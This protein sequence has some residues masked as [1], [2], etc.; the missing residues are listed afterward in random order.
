MLENK[1]LLDGLNIAFLLALGYYLAT[2]LQWYNYSIF[3]V[4][5]KHHKWR[6]HLLYFILPITLFISLSSFNLV[7]IFY[8]YFLFAYLPMLFFWVKKLDKPLKWTGRVYRFFGIYLLFILSDM[9]LQLAYGEN[10]FSYFFALAF[11][12]IFSNLFEYFLLN[13]YKKIATEKIA[14]MSHCK[15]ILITASYGKTSI[16]NYLTQILKTRYMVHSTPRSVNTLVGII[17]DINTE[18]DVRNEF[19]VVEAGARQKGDIAQIAQFLNPQYVIIGKLGEQHLEYFKSFENIVET[20][21]E[22]LQSNR[23]RYAF[24]ESSNPIPEYA[25]NKVQKAPQGIRNIVATLKGTSFELEIDG[26][27]H[28]FQTPVLGTF[29]A[30]NIALAIL[31]AKRVGLSLAEISAKVKKLNGVEHRL[32]RSDVNGRVILDDS[33]NGNLEGMK[34]A[35]RISS[36]HQGRKIIVTPGIVESTEEANTELAKAI[37]E[38]FEIAIITGELNSKILSDNIHKSK[39]IL[40]KEKGMLENTLKATV[41]DGD[42]ILFANDAP[43]YI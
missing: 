14:S 28:T 3:R 42:L 24:S 33:F 39:K 38:V 7:N 22:A 31:M 40:L 2:N 35:I 29:N 36:E 15:I 9:G 18:L 34:E 25:Q 6:W 16:K 5:T 27:W 10:H 20:K 32:H 4:I 43:S 11:S 37:D 26:N 30:Y 12:I 17:A 23:L 21:Y 1:M 19:Y 41:K 13:R 8:F